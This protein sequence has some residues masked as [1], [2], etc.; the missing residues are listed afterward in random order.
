MVWHV[1]ADLTIHRLCP[2]HLYAAETSVDLQ[3][4]SQSWL[5]KTGTWQA[6]N[7]QQCIDVRSPSISIEME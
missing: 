1:L 7:T 6:G 2:A 3:V 5:L 4:D